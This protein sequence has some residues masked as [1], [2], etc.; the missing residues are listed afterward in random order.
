ME[1]NQLGD[2]IGLSSKESALYYGLLSGGPMTVA[3]LARAVNLHR[4]DVY[5]VLPNLVE[6]GLVSRVVKGKRTIFSAQS[7]EKLRSMFEEVKQSFENTLP[8]LES[9]YQHRG[10]RTMVKYFE[11]KKGIASVYEDVVLSLKKH[12]VFYRYSSRKT[13]TDAEKF[14][15]PKYREI[16]EQKQLERFVITSSQ[17]SETKKNS[18]DRAIKNFPK[19]FGSFDYDIIELIYGD[20]IAFIDYASETATVIE[21][22]MMAEFQKVLFKLI[23]SKL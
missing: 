2:K 15:P 3:V 14:L 6:N 23:Y 22:K 1:F 5:K 13:T 20:K 12:D 8:E 21:N 4:P 9:L 18:L 17:I 11:G 16:R 7:P 19:E 10:T